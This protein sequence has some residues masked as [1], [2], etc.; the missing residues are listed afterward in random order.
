MTTT[1]QNL[2][3]G[4]GGF[5]TGFD[6]ASDGTML[7]RVDIF[8]AYTNSAVVGSS[9]NQIVKQ[10][11]MPAAYTS[12]PTPALFG[13]VWEVRIDPSNS[14]NM[15]MM[16]SIQQASTLTQLLKSTNK[17]TTWSQTGFPLNSAQSQDGSPKVTN[18]RIAIDP[19]NSNNI[20]A[21]TTTDL[22]VSQDGGT[23]FTQVS[24]GTLPSATAPYGFVGMQ[25]DP[26]TANR[27]IVGNTGNGVYVT[28]NS[29]LGASATWT[30]ITS[31]PTTPGRSKIGSDGNYYF[32]DRGATA[33]LYRIDTS[34]A[35]TNSTTTA[36]TNLD[37]F[38]I[39]PNNPARAVAIGF[40]QVT[41][42]GPV[43]GTVSWAAT[44]Q[45]N[46]VVATDAPWQQ[47]SFGPHST[48]EVYFD[49]FKTT[50]ATSVTIGT[51]TKTW[52]DVAL[53]LNLVVGDMVRVTNTGTATNYMLGTVS[54]YSA[55]TFSISV[56][57]SDPN[58]TGYL[59]NKTGGSGT[60]S[61]WTITKERLWLSTG[62]GMYWTDGIYTSS[63]SGGQDIHWNSINL[64][65][66]SLVAKQ[67]IWPPG[68]VPVLA[69][70][71]KPIFQV[72]TLGLTTGLS[73]FGP[74]HA[75]LG[76]GTAIDWASSTPSTIMTV[77]GTDQT[78]FDGIN[79]SSGAAGSWVAFTTPTGGGAEQIAVTD[80]NNAVVGT[81]SSILFTTNGGTS[82]AAVTGASIPSTGWALG[83]LGNSSNPQLQTICA[84]RVNAA[85]FYG[86]NISSN[87]GNGV[88]R[89]V[90]GAATLQVS[91]AL[92]PRTNLFAP[93]LKSVPA[94]G[95]HLFYTGGS[96]IDAGGSLYTTLAAT[97]AFVPDT[98]NYPFKFSSNAGAT[99][100]ALAT[101]S[102][103]LAFGFGAAKAQS[104]PSL[105]I[106]GYVSSVYGIWRC[107]N[108][109][110]ASLGS[111]IWT[112]VGTLARGWL[113]YPTT[114]EGNPSQWGQFIIGHQGS[115][116][117]I[118][119]DDGSGLTTIRLVHHVNIKKT[120]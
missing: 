105:Y 114:L 112:N 51:G 94:N 107:D 32:T 73:D 93:I 50:S 30:H 31:S 120:N 26:V 85:T 60:F 108:F 72:P 75:G 65:I 106:A 23:S 34:N 44:N 66:E 111:E 18:N 116:Y 21:S 92:D 69:N 36:A 29:N 81:P 76:E 117:A 56:L 41:L 70:A 61:A 1:I 110:P 98:T 80:A 109:N 24:G 25:F 67:V 2:N 95:G 59:G 118:G 71:D 5:S 115:G 28:A 89:I 52:T 7:M 86:L 40:G 103:V 88:Y 45:G 10:S 100:T 82:W 12:T 83:S 96:W 104:Y 19:N 35:L 22:Y 8:G 27:L 39:D 55:G 84:D 9:W 101:V 20:W 42:G 46:D 68:N 63:F 77:S 3:I 13:G 14:S 91:G 113:D 90:S 119:S 17:G 53:G 33:K 16:Y 64:G 11:S 99:W 49:P 4:A 6:M 48:S 37:A 79:T 57:A 78:A 102:G 87:T 58:S 38:A 15:W 47:F 74:T 62:F 97:L 54:T 43:N